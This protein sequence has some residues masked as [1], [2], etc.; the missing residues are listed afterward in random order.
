MRLTLDEIKVA[1]AAV[2]NYPQGGVE[3]REGGHSCAAD[4]IGRFSKKN[5]KSCLFAIDELYYYAAGW[6]H[7]APYESVIQ[8]LGIIYALQANPIWV[9]DCLKQ[10]I[11][12]AEGT[13]LVPTE[14]KINE[15]QHFVSGV[16]VT[17]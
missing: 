6:G 5:S 12:A 10:I 9:A 17:C 11:D 7:W 4:A 14:R 2:R 15:P 16:E 13:N 3:W 1:E 8:S